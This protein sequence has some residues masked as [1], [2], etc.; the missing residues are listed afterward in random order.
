MIRT[1]RE[2]KSGFSLLEVVIALGI[3]AIAVSSLIVFFA[4]ALETIRISKSVAQAT[5]IAQRKMEELKANPDSIL[6]MAAGPNPTPRTVAEIL[7]STPG[8]SLTSPK[9]PI[10]YTVT[11]TS[12]FIPN[13]NKRVID[14]V[15]TVSWKYKNPY[16]GVDNKRVVLEY[17]HIPDN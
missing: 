11:T 9:V 15:V 5:T 3:A 8:T 2:A 13:T 16:A 10:M 12:N 1:K 17:Y 7:Y 4:Y 6:E 14:V